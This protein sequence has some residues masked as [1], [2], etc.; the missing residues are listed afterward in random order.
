MSEQV[1]TVSTVPAVQVLRDATGQ[2]SASPG[3]REIREPEPKQLLVRTAFVGICGTDLEILHGRMP[4]T[5]LINYPH[6]LGHEWSGIVEAV[7]S[8]VTG[9]AV[10]DRV[11]GHGHLGA[12]DWFGVTHDGAASELFPVPEHMCFLIPENVDLLTA[13]IIEPFACVLNGLKKIGGVSAADTVH[14]YGLG[15]IGLATLIQAVTAR[16]KVVV[17][18]PSERRRAAA[19]ELGASAAV[20]PT[21]TGGSFERVEAAVGRPFADL[22]VEASGN[23]FA[24]VA[25]LESADHNGR[26]LLMGV[27]KPRL[28][29]ARLGLVQERNLTLSSSTG[30]P[31]SIWPEAIRYVANTGINLGSI[32]SSILPFSKA[33][34]A[35][36][37]AQDSRNEIK[38]MLAPENSAHLTSD[39]GMKS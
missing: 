8:E 10:G 1:L 15:A 21:I 5:F 19:L 36:A 17:F 4:E 14:I 12:N 35:I 7:G 6:V 26:V 32:V 28:V 13:A 38:V 20:D 31:A 2:I 34:E 37:R 30:A 25:A 33:E 18:D 22:V 3:T 16:A 29:E 27:S 39:Q 11:L 24:Q 23:P 9:F